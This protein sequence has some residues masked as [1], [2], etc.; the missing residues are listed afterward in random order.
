MP[1]TPMKT[2]NNTKQLSNHSRVLRYIFR[3]QPVS[4]SEIV[5]DLSL[6]R[7][8]VTSITA[9]LISQGV[10]TE[11]GKAETLEDGALG[12]RRLLIGIR[13]QAR[14]SAGVE[15][16]SRHFRF[17]ITDLA[18]NVHR[19]L[20]YA[21]SEEQIRRVNQSIVSGVEQLLQESGIPRDKILGIGVALPGHL[22]Q[23]SG[24][25]VTHSALWD[26]FNSH[27]LAEEM[28]F[29]VTA[30]NNVRAMAYE[31]YLFDIQSCPEDFALLHVGAG[32]FCADFRGGVLTEGSYISGE[33]GHTIS[34]PEGQRCECGKTG[35]LQTYASESWL[36]KKAQRIWQYNPHSALRQIVSSPDAITQETVLDAYRL[37]DALVV[38]E[39]REAL[40][41]LGITAA[42]IAI[43]LGAQKLYLHSRMFQDDMLRDDLKALIEGQLSFVGS[44][45][46]EDVSILDFNPWRAAVGAAALAI[47]RLFISRSS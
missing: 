47:D 16:G 36:I 43:I 8:L 44:Q 21:P 32:I 46:A 3:N 18:G 4:R 10:V 30:E 40:R 23:A 33:I 1:L 14:F 38:Q 41:Y 34:N 11:L 22:N 13:P 28:G 35:C 9:S 7:S 20:C 29:P 31:K 39:I 15:I 19:E 6:P 2:W 24:H 45:E 5:E 37:G 42:N 27:I 25:M 26:D 17:C 12:R